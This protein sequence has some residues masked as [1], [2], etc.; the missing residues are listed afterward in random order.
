MNTTR[1]FAI[2][3]LLCVAL[4]CLALSPTGASASE[5]QPEY[6][7]GAVVKIEIRNEKGEIAKHRAELRQ[8]GMDFHVEFEGTGAQH[9][10]FFHVIEAT[11]SQVKVKL[12]YTRD[13]QAIIANFENTFKAKKREILRTDNGIAHAFT[14]Q[15]KKVPRAKTERDDQIEPDGGDDPLGKNPLR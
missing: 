5:E 1:R 7:E 6:D 11:D 10:L 3:S 12:G 15:K 2:A 13:G 14:F 8:V 4:P 9:A